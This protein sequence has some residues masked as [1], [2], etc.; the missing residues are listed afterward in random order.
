MAEMLCPLCFR[1]EQ[2]EPSP[3]KIQTNCEAISPVP[4]F[5]EVRRDP[6]LAQFKEFLVDFHCLE[7]LEF[8]ESV[9]IYEEII[10]TEERE[11]Q[12]NKIF[13][14]FLREGAENDLSME[15]LLVSRVRKRMDDGEFEPDL[16][17]PLK[18]IVVYLLENDKYTLFLSERNRGKDLEDY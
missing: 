14:T 3:S 13:E 17:R 6:Y 1:A 9:E 15:E 12:A 16:F 18:N 5:L 7:F 8:L 4:S 2:D 11:R 10:D